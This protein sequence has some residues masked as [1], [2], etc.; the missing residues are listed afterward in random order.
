MTAAEPTDINSDIQTRYNLQ[1]RRHFGY[2]LTPVFTL[3]TFLAVHRT[4]VQLATLLLQ[5][6]GQQYS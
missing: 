4:A 2:N 5:Y 3:Q 1:T 6:T